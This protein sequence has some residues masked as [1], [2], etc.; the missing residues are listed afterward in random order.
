MPILKRL[1]SPKTPQATQLAEMVFAFVVAYLLLGVVIHS[2]SFRQHDMVGTVAAL[3]KIALFLILLILALM[4]LRLA[5]TRSDNTAVPVGVRGGLLVLCLILTVLFPARTLYEIFS[6]A[7]PAAISAHSFNYMLGMSV[8][9]LVFA[10]LAVLSFVA[11]LRLWLVKAH[12][13]AFAR[14][15][16]VTYLIANIAYLLFWMAVFRPPTLDMY[17]KP[18]VYFIIGPA[19]FVWVWYTYLEESKRVRNTYPVP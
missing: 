10:P 8:F 19:I 12:A 5:F 14:R 15:F 2:P 13:V 16:L 3:L 18:S 11:G 1:L 4:G 17:E 7:V 9:S 6:Y